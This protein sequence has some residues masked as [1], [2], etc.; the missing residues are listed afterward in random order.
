MHTLRF[1]L[2]SVT[3]SQ[4]KIQK[5]TLPKIGPAEGNNDVTH[6]GPATL[7]KI[8]KLRRVKIFKNSWVFQEVFMKNLMHLIHYTSYVEKV[9]VATSSISAKI[10]NY[11][12]D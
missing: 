7:Q 3:I 12:Y 10:E 6:D 4:P 8:S 1:E 2:V 11:Y 5:N 9:T